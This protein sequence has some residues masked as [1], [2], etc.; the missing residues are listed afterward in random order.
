MDAPSPCAI[1]LGAGLRTHVDAIE[2]Y[3]SAGAVAERRM[4]HGPIL[5]AVN[6]LATEHGI[7]GGWYAAL[8]GQRQQSVA[9]T[10]TDA[11]L[12]VVQVQ[13][14]GFTTELPGSIRLLAEKF[15]NGRLG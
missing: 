4:E 1:A 5:C 10:S 12:A 9:N 11:I 14:R 7:D 3:L 13:A 8:L 15:N 2:K 6:A